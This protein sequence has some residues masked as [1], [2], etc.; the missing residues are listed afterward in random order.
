VD[1]Q[2][3]AS[4]PKQS[5]LVYFQ[6]QWKAIPQW[7]VTNSNSPSSFSA[8]SFRIDDS[9]SS[10]ESWDEM[11]LFLSLIMLLIWSEI[12]FLFCKSKRK[13]MISQLLQKQNVWPTVLGN[14]TNGQRREM[15]FSYN[16][17][18][19][20]PLLLEGRFHSN[21]V[22]PSWKIFTSK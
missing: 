19:L 3:N 8:A 22:K 5:F 15:V 7:N 10:D 11:F 14:H 1:F 12:S 20:N 17:L 4:L 16:F 2:I 18:R 13:R 21:M 9:R 6:W